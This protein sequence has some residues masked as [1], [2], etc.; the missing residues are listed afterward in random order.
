MSH[1]PDLGIIKAPVLE[2][3]PKLCSAVSFSMSDIVIISDISH[4]HHHIVR[5]NQVLPLDYILCKF[6][7][8]SSTSHILHYLGETL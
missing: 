4:H 8:K 3:S 6:F 1:Y 5:R 2:E 7:S